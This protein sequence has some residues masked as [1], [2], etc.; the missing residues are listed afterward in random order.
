[1]NILA[2]I[3][4]FAEFAG[5]GAEIVDNFA[6]RHPELDEGPK[7]DQQNE[8]EDAHAKA[9]AKRFPTE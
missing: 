7:P 1:M 5:I 8:I 3:K 6:Q 4:L 2:W 9:L